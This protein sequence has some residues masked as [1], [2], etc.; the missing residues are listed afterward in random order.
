MVPHR[1]KV[2]GPDEPGFWSTPLPHPHVPGAVSSYCL[3][4]LHPA[5]KDDTKAQNKKQAQGR[6][7]QRDCN[8]GRG[9]RGKK[10]PPPA[11][12]MMGKGIPPGRIPAEAQALAPK[13]DAAGHGRVI[14]RSRQACQDLRGNSLQLRR[15]SC[16]FK[17]VDRICT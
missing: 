13:N 6:V 9:A 17:V 3:Y 12:P 15:S 10:L 1:F 16:D 5:K 2:E 7:L 8:L 14:L 11:F 4:T